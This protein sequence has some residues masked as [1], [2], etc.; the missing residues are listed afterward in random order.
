[1]PVLT[2]RARAGRRGPRWRCCRSRSARTGS[3]RG[4]RP[5]RRAPMRPRRGR[6]ARWRSP[7]SAC[8]GSDRRWD[9]RARRRARSSERTAAGGHS[10][11]VREHDRV[12]RDLGDA[13]GDLGDPA[14][15]HLTLERAPE[16]DAERDRAANAV[17]TRPR[18]DT[19]RGRDRVLDCGALV[20][21]VERLR[22]AEREPHLVQSGRDEALV[23]T[24]VQSQSG[25]DESRTRS[26]CRGDLLRTCHLGYAS[27]VD[28]AGDLD[29]RNTRVGQPPRELGPDVHIEDLGLVLQ[30]VPWPDVIDRDARRSHR[31][32]R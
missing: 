24:F 6:P 32:A 1:M 5:T 29:P 2:P 20:A 22:D 7:C 16:R 21:L 26:H 12:R 14:R 3:H 28:E 30:P 27:R 9:S 10:D 17:S 11:R 18:S 15:I 8:C 23:A 31:R 19:E 25:A 13:L 4:R